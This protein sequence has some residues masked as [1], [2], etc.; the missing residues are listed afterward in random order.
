M[1]GNCEISWLTPVYPSLSARTMS[2]RRQ[3]NKRR[4]YN[5]S[6]VIASPVAFKAKCTVINA[7]LAD[8]GYQITIRAR[9]LRKRSSFVVRRT[10]I[11]R[12]WLNQ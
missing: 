2:A 12:D 6:S 8:A 5:D 1:P 4:E 7:M 9:S 3:N 10:L 11:T